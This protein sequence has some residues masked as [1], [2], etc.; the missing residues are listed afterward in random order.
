MRFTCAACVAAGLIG[1]VLVGGCAANK[2]PVDVSVADNATTRQLVTGQ[3]LRVSLESNP[4][5]G[6]RWALDGS[7]PAQLAQ[8]GQPQ[9]TSHSNAV[10]SGG[11]EL[12]TFVAKSSGTAPL[13]LKYWRSFE[14]TVPPI[15]TFSLNV[16]VR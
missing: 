4:T 16:E 6:Y 9:F 10:G 7:L 5:T 11:T 15:A 3:K 14:P 12:W 13:R 1:L 8:V 2:S